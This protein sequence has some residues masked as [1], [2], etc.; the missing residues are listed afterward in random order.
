MSMIDCDVHNTWK[1]VD[2]LRP[3]LA[4]TFR[5]WFDEGEVPGS[6]PAFPAAHRAWLHP[7]DF[8]RV[9]AAPGDGGNPGS[10]YELMRHQLLDR[11]CLDYAVLTGDEPIEVSTLANPYYAQA[12]ASAYN[13]YVIDVWLPRDRRL[14]ASLVVAPQDPRGAAEEIRRLGDHPDVVQVLVSSGSQRPYGDPFY[15]PIWEACAELGLPFAIHLG[16]NAGINAGPSGCGSPTFFWEA[17]ALLCQTG[18]GHLASAIAHGVFE[19]WPTTRMV[20]IECGIAWVPALLWRLDEDYRALRKETPWLRRLP[21]EYAQDHIRMTT[22]PLEQ[23]H[24]RDALWPSL[25]DIGGRDM[26]LFASD[27]PHWDFDDPQT[28]RLPAGWR[29]RILDGNARELYR[30]PPGSDES[31]AEAA[32]GTQLA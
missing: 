17:H 19:R 23:P 27:Y 9:D 3:Y 29:D 18:M 13:D 1:T 16:G 22:Q 25:A 14:R 32:G 21:S 30:L 24:D 12:L 15:H 7:S 10:D 2:E 8:K 4:P 5:Q 31:V 20:L 11:Y 28:L 26:L 6:R